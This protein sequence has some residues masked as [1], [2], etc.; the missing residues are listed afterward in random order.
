MTHKQ[1]DVA[2][3]QVVCIGDFEVSWN[4]ERDRLLVRIQPHVSTRNGP[5]RISIILAG[6]SDEVWVAVV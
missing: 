2:P 6:E 1:L 5:G 4:E 3:G